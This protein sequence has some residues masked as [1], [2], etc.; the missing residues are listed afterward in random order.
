MNTIKIYL[1]GVLNGSTSCVRSVVN[2]NNATLYLG[3][4]DYGSRFFR[5]NISS[6]TIHNRALT[7]AEILSNFN[8]TRGRFGL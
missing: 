8:S 5:G 3:Q 2:S 4:D 1:N 7:V 6:V